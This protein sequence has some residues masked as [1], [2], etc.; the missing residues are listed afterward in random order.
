M[1]ETTYYILAINPGSTSTKIALYENEQE[2]FRES[3]E[4]SNAELA[5]YPT[6]IAQ[7]TMR[8]ETVLA[9]LHKHA[10]DEH[11]LSAVVGRGGLLPPLRSGA[12]CVNEAMVDRLCTNPVAEHAANLGAVIAYDLAAPLGIPA[13]IYDSVSVDELQPIARYSGSPEL[14]RRSLIHALNMRA[15]AIKTAQ[16]LNKPYREMTLIV[17]HLGGGIS[18]SVHQGGKM[19]DIV[20]DDE[21]PFSPERTGRVPCIA[22]A[23]LCYSG[24]FTQREM[25]KHLRGKGGLIAYLN[26]N[27]AVDVQKMIAQG[28]EEARLIFE[29]MAYQIAKGIGELA[30]V[31]KGRVDRIVLTGGVA[32]SEMI[33]TW[34]KERVEFIA[35]VEILPGENELESLALGAL[36]VLQGEEQAYDYC[37]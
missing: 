17:A 10:V 6:I 15:A 33:T 26:T 4:H 22:L 7:H 23:E 5:R 8:K 16:K 37:E 14:P 31:V 29:A 36:R 27:K 32:C 28:N 13:Y 11:R 12:Y 9:F 1:P 35:P 2:K 19:I 24:K 21:G 18:M 34:V 30:T 20:S 25:I 3:L